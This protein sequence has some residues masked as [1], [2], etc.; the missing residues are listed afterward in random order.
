MK[1]LTSLSAVLVFLIV[2]FAAESFAKSATVS[3]KFASE[4]PFDRWAKISEPTQGPASA[5]GEYSAGCVAGAA[6]L[7]DVGKGFVTMRPSRK[8]YYGHPE[9]I[10]YIRALGLRLQNEKLPHM[11][12]GNLSPPRGGPM[13]S[14]HVSHQSGLDVDIWFMM[15]KKLPTKKER[16]TWNAPSYV[17]DRK[18]LKSNWSQDQVK[19]ISTAADFEQVNRIFVSPAVKKY[20]CENFPT[21][22]WLHKIRSWWSHHDHLHVRLNCPKDSSTCE[23]QPPLDPAMTYCGSDL[24]WWFS[25]EADEEWAEMIKNPT[26]RQFPTLPAVCEEMTKDAA[27]ARST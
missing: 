25:K 27:P 20:F 12:V 13:R 26:P 17:T 4:D 11:L 21:A 24:D 6:K 7:E 14:G 2:G 10:E 8:R 23:P 3:T 22:P 15:S 5:I 16:E 9:L 1:L 18:V 19:L